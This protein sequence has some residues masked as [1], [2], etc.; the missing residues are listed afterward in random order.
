MMAPVLGIDIGGTGLKAALVDTENGKMV[1]PRRR[2][3]TPQPAR[4]AAVC[5]AIAALVAAEEFAGATRAGAGFPGVIKGGVAFT[6]ANLGGAWVGKDV[7]SL[8]GEAIAKPVSVAN[9]ADVAGL[10]E[11]RFGAG[12]GHGGEILMVTL[13]TGIGCGFFHNGML[14]PNTELGHIEIN[15]KDAEQ[16]AAALVRERKKLSWKRW[17][18]DVEAYLQKLE[19]LI[20]PDLIII[21]GGVSATP[22]KFLPLITTRTKVVPATLG[23]EAGIIGAALWAAE[24]ERG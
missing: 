24:Q 11:V 10:A 22:E 8:L 13:G 9:D 12:Q 19:A 23:N 5:A 16:T 6:A 7:A 4:P 17:A 1:T 18:R 21:G 14:I 15:G 20:W 3:L 2:V